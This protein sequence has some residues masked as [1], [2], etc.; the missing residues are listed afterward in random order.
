MY[1]FKELKKNRVHALGIIKLGLDAEKS[2]QSLSLSLGLIFFT[3]SFTLK[4][5]FSEKKEVLPVILRRRPVQA[6]ARPSW[7]VTQGLSR[8][9]WQVGDQGR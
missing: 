3:V 7:W 1:W 2:Q 6:S 8:S 5:I 4:A 9:P